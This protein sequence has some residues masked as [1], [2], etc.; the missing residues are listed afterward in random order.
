VDRAVAS[1]A[2]PLG[3]ALASLV[4][5][6]LSPAELAPLARSLVR[7]AA[8]CSPPEPDALLT[9]LARAAIATLVEQLFARSVAVPR[10]SQAAGL[11]RE[12]YAFRAALG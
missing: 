10:A 8:W 12:L 11:L 5:D 9:P 4:P 1:L 6:S 2:P 3:R 7:A